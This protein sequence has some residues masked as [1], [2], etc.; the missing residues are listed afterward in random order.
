MKHIKMFEEFEGTTDEMA[1]ATD[2]MASGDVNYKAIMK[3]YH[4]GSFA[5]KKVG[6]VICKNPNATQAQIEEVLGEAGYE[7][8]VE[9]LDAL[10]IHDDMNESYEELEHYMFFGN[11]ETIK[12]KCEEILSRD[13]KEIDELLK[14]GHDWAADHVAVA[15]DNILQVETFIDNHFNGEPQEEIKTP[16]ASDTFEPAAGKEA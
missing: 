12:R 16:E 10:G 2:E 5:K 13:F 15:K 14:N 7:D 1:G 9:F 6:A 4:S 8:M 3:M 11:L